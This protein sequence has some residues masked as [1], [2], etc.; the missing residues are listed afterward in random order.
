MGT[1]VKT[2]LDHFVASN[3]RNMVAFADALASFDAAAMRSVIDRIA[4]S[5]LVTST[6]NLLNTSSAALGEF[7]ERFKGASDFTKMIAGLSMTGGGAMLWADAAVIVMQ[8][9]VSAGIAVLSIK[10]VAALLILYGI[11]IALPALWRLIRRKL[12]DE[13]DRFKEALEN[14]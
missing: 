2:H 3:H 14:D 10:V 1:S 11:S 4:E 12:D 13:F 7:I 8:G 6:A 5:K 9:A